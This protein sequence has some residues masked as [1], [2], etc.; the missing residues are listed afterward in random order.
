VYVPFLEDFEVAK[1]TAV[2]I[3]RLKFT[4]KQIPVE[5]DEK[6]YIRITS[7]PMLPPEM[8]FILD[9]L[10]ES[11]LFGEKAKYVCEIAEVS[12]EF[13]NNLAEFIRKVHIEKVERILGVNVNSV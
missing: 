9:V 5:Y 8:L 3:D 7:E 6:L 1:I 2:S 4:S 13:E 10:P 12:E 11:L